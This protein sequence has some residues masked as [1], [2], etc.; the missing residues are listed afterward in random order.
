MAVCYPRV[1]KRPEA[2][3]ENHGP[4]LLTV[5][6]DIALPLTG[7]RTVPSV[8]HENYWFRRHEV[9]YQWVRTR[10]AR[11]LRGQRTIDA[12][13][14]EGYGAAL[15]AQV[16]ERPVISLE[17][18]QPT[19]RH[20]NTRYRPAIAV[21][22]AN[23][24]AFPLADSCAGA[25]V[26]MQV[27][28]HLWDLAGFLSECRRV[29][30]PGGLMVL[31]TPNRLTFSPGLGRGQKPTNPFHVEEFD[32]GQLVDIVAGAGFDNVHAWGLHHAGKLAAWERKHGDIVAAQV[33][34]V[35]NNP[36]G[37]TQ[38]ESWDPELRAAVNA[39]T[40]DDFAI[41]RENLAQCR[42]LIVVANRAKGNT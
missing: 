7:E 42:D 18:D 9:A 35:L 26:S 5:V 3:P 38:P 22:V 10:W 1:T 24:N 2:P 34:N 14:G 4:N 33:A 32:A 17:L 28:E 11:P 37:A 15:L 16:T 12:G 19:A 27:V 36:T 31:T 29:L 13:C 25:L 40:H 20:A 23:L 39:V 30:I 41:S 21:L 8:D 6:D